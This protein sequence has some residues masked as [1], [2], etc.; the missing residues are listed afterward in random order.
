M[1]A[2]VTLNSGADVAAYLQH[3]YLE[4][5]TRSV[6][7]EIFV[8]EAV[9]RKMLEHKILS[10][11]DAEVLLYHYLR[12]GRRQIS[13]DLAQY[14]ASLGVDMARVLAYLVE[15]VEDH[16]AVMRAFYH[17]RAKGDYDRKVHLLQN[18]LDALPRVSSGRALD[19]ACGTGAMGPFI[20]A[21][22]YDFLHG[23]DL[24]PEMLETCRNK[25]QYDQLTAGAISAVIA[26]GQFAGAYDLV[27][28]IGLAVDVPP[29]EMLEAIRAAISCLKS[30]GYLVLNAATDDNG[31]PMGRQAGL[32]TQSHRAILDLFAEHHMPAAWVDHGE[33]CNAR[34]VYWGSRP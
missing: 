2:T 1:N 23:I 12:F 18:P 6:D 21:R 27:T 4:S 9:S 33:G 3:Y 15:P 8:L 19:L 31:Y 24:S 14:I 22:G 25:G 13:I 16:I 11:H 20:R 26:T 34:R 32:K 29:C 7:G 5:L 10:S 28:I 17:I 30:G